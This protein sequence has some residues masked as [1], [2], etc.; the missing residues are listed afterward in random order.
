MGKTITKTA[1]NVEDF[2]L[3]RDKDGT[4]TLIVGYTVST[5]EGLA[6]NRGRSFQ[7]TDSFE[8][9]ARKMFTLVEDKLKKEEEL[10]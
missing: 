6:I 3:H 2:R 8:T 9:A 7:L 10:A 4:V 5:D 1:L